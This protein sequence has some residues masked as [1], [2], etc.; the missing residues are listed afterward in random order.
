MEEFITTNSGLSRSEIIN[1]REDR[2]W[3]L[4]SQPGGPNMR[5]VRNP[6]D[7]KVIDM[8]HMLVVGKYPAAI[9]NIL[10]AY[11]WLDGQASGM[12]RQDF[13]SNSVGYQF[14][15]QYNSFQNAIAP[16]I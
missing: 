7:G 1:Q 14:Y 6:H 5:Y 12:D 4:G 15:M 3:L 16:T 2:S 10:E 9:G 8:R 11:Q 13:Y